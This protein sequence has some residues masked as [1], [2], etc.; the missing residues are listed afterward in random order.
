MTITIDDTLKFEFPEGVSCIK[1]DETRTHRTLSNAWQFACACENCPSHRCSPKKRD[2]SCSKR[3]EC[4]VHPRDGLKA[5]DIVS[6]LNSELYLIEV[7]D[8]NRPHAFKKQNLHDDSTLAHYIVSIAKKFRDTLF[9]I[10][11]G[12]SFMQDVE[13]KRFAE[14]CRR[15]SQQ[16]HLV[17]H[18]ERPDVPYQSG[19][20]QKGK[21]IS[22]ETIREA[23]AKYIGEALSANFRVVDRAVMADD[24]QLLPWKVARIENPRG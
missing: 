16:V 15:N 14:Q 17:F 13:E 10:W 22:A 11:V 8:F 24:P 19:F 2:A 9:S 4:R 3:S 7:K 18:C 5:V 1:W 6:I 23:I 21:S 20:F 12:S